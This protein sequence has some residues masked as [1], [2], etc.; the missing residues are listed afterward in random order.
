[1]N[2]ES[3]GEYSEI[4]HKKAQKAPKLIKLGFC[5]FCA[6]LRLR[7]LRCCRFLVLEHVTGVN[8]GGRIDRH[9]SFVDV[10]DDAFF[11]D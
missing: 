1:M 3:L 11:V 4:G 9:V 7:V 10:P 5:A 8:H 6:F 2:C